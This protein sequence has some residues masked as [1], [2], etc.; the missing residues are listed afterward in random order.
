MQ[1]CTLPSQIARNWGNPQPLLPLLG[2][3]PTQGQTESAPWG[4]NCPRATCSS[5]K[6]AT[7]LHKS[8]V[9]QHRTRR[10]GRV[11]SQERRPAQ[12]TQHVCAN[13]GCRLQNIS[14]TTRCV[15]LT[16]ETAARRSAGRSRPTPPTSKACSRCECIPTKGKGRG[17]G[18]LVTP[19]RG[20]G[21]LENTRP[22]HT[23]ESS[24]HLGG[25]HACTCTDIPTYPLVGPS[26]H[27]C[28][29]VK[30][31]WDSDYLPPLRSIFLCFPAYKL[32]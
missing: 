28:T 6:V 18:E 21:M 1:A 16:S 20:E 11:V 19:A 13:V 31:G 29:P 12:P 8:F 9:Q 17:R 10:G 4:S 22:G 32:S 25:I 23:G 7:R 5:K 15:T 3:L 14:V 24:W 26:A 30:P 27:A 2:L